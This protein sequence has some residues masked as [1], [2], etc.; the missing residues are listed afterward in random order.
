MNYFFNKKEDQEVQR[1]NSECKFAKKKFY[2]HC[3]C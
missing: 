2:T 3:I 1:G